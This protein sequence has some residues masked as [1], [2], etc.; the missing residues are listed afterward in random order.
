MPRFATTAVSKITNSVVPK[1][2][3]TVCRLSHSLMTIF[4]AKTARIARGAC[5]KSEYGWK[6]GGKIAL[7]LGK[8][9]LT[10]TAVFFRLKVGIAG[11]AFPINRNCGG[12]R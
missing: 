2:R 12:V 9:S 7:M 8:C 1:Y 4:K 10:L 5:M 3:S 6:K 11:G